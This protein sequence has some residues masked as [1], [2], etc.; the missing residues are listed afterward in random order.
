MTL[1]QKLSWL[2]RMGVD[3]TIGSATVN[4]LANPTPQSPAT[5]LN[6]TYLTQ[7]D[8]A[9][10]QAISLANA[11]KTLAELQQA[12]ISF[13][14]CALK[15]TSSTTVFSKGTRPATVMCIGDMPDTEDDKQGLPF[16]GDSGALLD[17]MLSAIGLST[18][19]N[20]YVSTL[21]PWRPPGN[22]KPTGSE[23]ALCLPFIKRHIELVQPDIL[24]LFGGLTSGAILGVDSISKA[25]GVWHDYQPEHAPAPIPCLV[26]FS[27]AFLLKTPTH[28]KHAWED[29]QRLQT[30]LG[31]KQE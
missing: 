8:N 17:K 9:L 1:Y 14:G 3:E 15:K 12:L 4:R 16:A 19:H 29:L 2:L 25:R 6:P 5:R 21:I 28:K 20:T 18:A 7:E 11:A 31:T 22:R 24:L 13:E 23:V 30:K 10:K 27:P 26:T